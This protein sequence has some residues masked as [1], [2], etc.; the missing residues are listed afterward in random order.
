MEKRQII[1][2]GDMKV[3]M[4]LVIV[5]GV[6]PGVVPVHDKVNRWTSVDEPRQLVPTPASGGRIA[7]RN[8]TERN[9]KTVR[10]TRRRWRGGHRELHYVAAYENTAIY[11]RGHYLKVSLLASGPGRVPVDRGG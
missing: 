7:T 3:R 4:D 5:D 2:N 1:H 6:E 11:T 9:M 8:V 10:V